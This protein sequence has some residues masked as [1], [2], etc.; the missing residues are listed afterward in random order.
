MGFA[1]PNGL[2][3]LFPVTYGVP[4][5]PRG[6]SF[7]N[8]QTV[9]LTDASTSSVIVRQGSRYQIS[10]QVQGPPPPC[11]L[12]RT[13]WEFPKI[14]LGWLWDLHS[15]SRS[16]RQTAKV[17]SAMLSTKP[18]SA[19]TAST[20]SSLHGVSQ[21]DSNRFS[22]IRTAKSGFRMNRGISV[23]DP[24]RVPF[25]FAPAI[26]HIGKSFP[27]A[28]PSPAARPSRRHQSQNAPSLL[29]IDLSV[30]DHVRYKYKLEV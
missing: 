17:S 9:L 7:A 27:T 16:A 30:P 20:R 22:P 4:E 15:Q 13:I 19:N 18:V 21:A 11:V 5:H 23:A 8:R 3:A 2:S 6:S 28:F 26:I 1:T 14:I 24:F 25:C 10:G 12:A 29:R